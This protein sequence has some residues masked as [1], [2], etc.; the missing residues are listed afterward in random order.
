MENKIDRVLKINSLE[1]LKIVLDRHAIDY[2][3]WSGEKNSAFKSV[4]YLFKEIQEKDCILVEKDNNLV[5]RLRVLALKVF[6]EDEAGKYVLVEEKQE[7]SDGSKR[8]RKKWSSVAE[9]IKS[10]EKV[11]EN[12]IKRALSEELGIQD[13]FRTKF[14]DVEVSQESNNPSFP[15]ILSEYPLYKYEIYLEK[16]VFNKDGYIEKQDGLTTYFAWHNV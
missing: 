15:G 14:L 16:N 3:S 5:R 6:F 1:E 11:D 4:D 10:D 12:L 9:K 7:F 13:C 8:I 2:L